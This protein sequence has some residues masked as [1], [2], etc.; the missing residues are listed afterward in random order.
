[1]PARRRLDPMNS[2]KIAISLAAVGA[3]ASPVIVGTWQTRSNQARW[4]AL[5]PERRDILLAEMERSKNCRFYETQV[6]ARDIVGLKPDSDDISRAVLCHR[7]REELDNGGRA[8]RYFSLL[9][10]LSTNGAVTVASFVGIFALA[11][12]LLGVMRRYRLWL[13]T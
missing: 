3:V 12:V 13:K 4:I 8:E 9:R 1:M 5:T 10:Y 6:E 11:I 2:W 7:E